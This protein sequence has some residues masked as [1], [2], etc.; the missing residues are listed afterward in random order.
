VPEG[1]EAETVGGADAA[2]AGLELECPPEL[3]PAA[4]AA[5]RATGIR[6]GHLTI[7]LVDPERI[8]ELNRRHRGL[9][10][11]T[12]VLSFPVDEAGPS[13][14]PRELG[15]VV[16]CPEH[17]RD[18][19]EAAVHGVLHLAGHDHDRDDGEMLAL[20]TRVLEELR[21]RT[22]AGFIAVAGRPNVGKSTLVNALVG[23]KVA[24]ISDKPQTTR[25]AIRGVRSGE[26]ENGRWQLV[27]VD[28]PGVQ[29]PR[30]M[31]TERMQRRVEREL[32]ECDGVLFVLNGAEE[33]GGG[34]R[35]IAS[36]LASSSVPIIAALNKVDLLS[37]GETVAALDAV[38]RLEAEGVEL[39]EI[40]PV[41]ARTGAGV[42]PLLQSLVALL[43][44]GPLLYPVE[45]R[46]DQPLERALAELIREQALARTREEVPHS[47]EVNVE[48]IE[49]GEGITNVRAVIWVEAASQKGILI[50]RGGRMIRDV[51]TGARFEIERL[52]NE[53]VF[54]NLT[55][56]VRRGWRRDEGLLDRLGI[57]G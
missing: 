50:G 40:F 53:Q 42:E 8:R 15:D 29:R 37:K 16:I 3:R 35:F 27:L 17:T 9:D 34:D 2:E 18:L 23:A 45:T 24:V 25:R 26:E 30:D 55:V 4:G 32:S 11:A 44:R 33:I 41:S 7:E 14:G 19:E 57:E 13:A 56:K 31:L 28:L 1:T 48:D 5:I 20:Q 21:G 36:A 49:A 54:L 22:R 12:D 38:A 10:E 46:T 51:G 43:P 6:D 47:I 39:R 52:L